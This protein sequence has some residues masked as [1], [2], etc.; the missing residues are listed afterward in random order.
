MVKV[1]VN[2]ESTRIEA[3]GRTPDVI[4]ELAHAMLAIM[5]MADKH[6]IGSPVMAMVNHGIDKLIKE[7]ETGGTH[8]P[9]INRKEL[10]Q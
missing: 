1:E 7:K 3:D 5:K 2:G 6:D 10:L 4:I 8:E 9:E